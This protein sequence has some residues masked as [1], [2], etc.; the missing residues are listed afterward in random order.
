MSLFCVRNLALSVT[1]LLIPI[2]I[3]GAW[4]PAVAWVETLVGRIVVSW[5]GIRSVA[6][7]PTRPVTPTISK[8]RTA[9]IIL[10]VAIPMAPAVSPIIPVIAIFFMV[11]PTIPVIVMGMPIIPVTMM[12]VTVPMPMVR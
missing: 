4:I 10:S 12:P 9:I 8:P 2:I 3:I 5:G 1:L 6:R 11:V 7:I